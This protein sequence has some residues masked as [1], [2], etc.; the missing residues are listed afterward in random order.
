MTNSA[1]IDFQA[2]ILAAGMG[3]RMRSEKVKVLHE[4]LGKPMISHV[5]DTA[6]SAGAARVIS[7]LG[8]QRERVQTYLSAHARA[9]DLCYAIQHEQLGTAHAVLAGNAFFEDA[10]AYTVILSGDVPN[11][12]ADTLQSFVAEAVES[13]APL[14]VMTAKLDDAKSYGRIIR[15]EA[16]QVM[17]I[18]EYRDA[19]EEQRKIGEFNAGIYVVRT[20]F[21]ARHLPG[22][23][24][25]PANNAQR[26]YYLTDLIAIA[27]EQAHAHG[28]VVPNVELV[29]GVNNRND[30]SAAEKFARERL[31]Q[32]WM[33]QGVTLLDPARITIETDV[34][35]GADVTLFPDVHLRGNTSIG[36]GTIIENG[37][38]LTDTQVGENSVLKAYCYATSAKLGDKTTI[39]PFVQL[40]P[41]TDIGNDCKVGNFVELKNT[42]MDDGSKANHLSYLGDTHVGTDANVGAG[43]ITCNYDGTNKNKTEIGAGAFIGSNTSLIAPVRVGTGAYVAAGSTI[44]DDVPDEALGVARGRQKNIDG[45]ATDKKK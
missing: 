7:V 15:N 43:T 13:G 35:I 42:R 38:V 30:L 10:P 21:L 23:C 5:I 45:W 18:V 34:N 24:S 22:L 32:Y 4:V 6:F 17:A 3:T 33:E 11:L 14:T 26:E 40:R 31:N 8:H 25:V 16:G 37:C 9:K 39:G 27:A 20:E 1:Q 44:T 41:H 28:F 29:Q 2:L 12:D 36:A 19:S